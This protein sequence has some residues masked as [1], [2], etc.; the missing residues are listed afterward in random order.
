M[1]DPAPVK[2][3]VAFL[4]AL[5]ISRNRERHECLVLRETSDLSARRL[6]ALKGQQVALPKVLQDDLQ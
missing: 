5:R 2:R 6:R 4:E 1:G 3:L